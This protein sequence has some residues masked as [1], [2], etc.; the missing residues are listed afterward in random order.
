MR[1]KGK[2]GK[3]VTRL[4]V[5]P[6]TLNSKRLAWDLATADRGGDADSIFCPRKTVPSSKIQPVTLQQAPSPKTQCTDAK[7]AELL[8]A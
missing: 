1:N 6:H 5:E 4:R 8:E 2:E 3:A 7:V